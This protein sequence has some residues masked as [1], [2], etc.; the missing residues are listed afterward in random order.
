LLIRP[1]AVRGE[2]SWA[3][4]RLLIEPSREASRRRIRIVLL[5]SRSG[6]GERAVEVEVDDES[7]PLY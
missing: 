4:V 5:R 1:A 6:F 7:H 2:P 3:D